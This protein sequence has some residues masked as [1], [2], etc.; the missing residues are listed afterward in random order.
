MAGVRND[1]YFDINFIYNSA[2]IKIDRK[3]ILCLIHLLF[4]WRIWPYFFLMKG[5]TFYDKIIFYIYVE[6]KG[7]G[8]LHS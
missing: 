6:L 5:G 2:H 8:L 3:I 1:Q 4:L 7:I